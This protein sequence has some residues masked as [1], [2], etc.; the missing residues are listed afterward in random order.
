MRPSASA[1]I[2]ASTANLGPGFD[3]L[4]LALD[5]YN[6]VTLRA[7]AVTEV[8]VTGEGV[9]RLPE[10][11]ANLVLR[12]AAKLAKR[13]GVQLPGWRLEQHNEIPLA[14][15]LGSSSAAIVGGLVACDRLLELETPAAELLDLATELEGHPDNVAPALFGGLTVC[16]RDGDRTHCLRLPAPEG[17]YVAVVI[18]DF[19]VSTEAARDALPDSYP[20][21][22]AVYNVTHACL[23]LAALCRGRYD[24]LGGAMQDR[25]HQP[26]RL[27]LVPGMAEVIEA[28]LDAGASGAALSGSGPAVAAFCE[29]K[30][31]SV[32]EAMEQA[33]A[34]EGIRSR[35]LWLQ[36]AT[37]ALELV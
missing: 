23:T 11:P 8:T 24:L 13:A 25:I 20:R 9:G 35:T 37:G 36:P 34:R 18:P 2:P 6:T 5:L 10:S 19:E 3:C 26:Y 16:A 15:G 32:A 27:P 4:G 30:Y 14:R 1:R 12:A 21:A 31:H 17:L 22:D 33:F 7:A 29:E 28:A